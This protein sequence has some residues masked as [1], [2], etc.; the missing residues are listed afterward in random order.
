M[1]LETYS[2]SA[3]DSALEYR[4]GPAG[5]SQ[6]ERQTDYGTDCPKYNLKRRNECKEGKSVFS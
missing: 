6:V 5:F 2:M 3:K 1:D 4:E